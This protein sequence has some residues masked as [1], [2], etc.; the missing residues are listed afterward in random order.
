MREC[1]L[2]H[3]VY[4]S[5]TTLFSTCLRDVGIVCP[6]HHFSHTHNRARSTP[7]SF[8]T[9]SCVAIKKFLFFP[10]SSTFVRPFW[11]DDNLLDATSKH[12]QREYRRWICTIAFT[13]IPLM[14]LNTESIFVRMVVQSYR[15]WCTC[16]RRRPTCDCMSN[17]FIYTWEN[18]VRISD[19]ELARFSEK[20]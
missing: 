14:N 10:A 17:V 5:F 3:S 4:C 12:H 11:I 16:R 13:H 7:T 1:S 8:R 2:V 19:G 15:Y 18:D 9:L 6:V 20:F